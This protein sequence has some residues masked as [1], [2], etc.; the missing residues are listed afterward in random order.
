MKTLNTT[1]RAIA[2]ALIFTLML[3]CTASFADGNQKTKVGE[4]VVINETRTKNTEDE[5]GSLMP[6]EEVSDD[7][8]V[9]AKPAD[10]GPVSNGS[11]ETAMGRE[12]LINGRNEAA[13]PLQSYEVNHAA[14][15]GIAPFTGLPDAGNAFTPITITIHLPR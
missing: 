7:G 12:T 14:E 10:D 15:E 9:S 13:V 3:S 5:L 4:S 6:L 8:S 2:M 11:Y 1:K